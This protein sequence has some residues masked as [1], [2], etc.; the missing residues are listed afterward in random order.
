MLDRSKL[1]N[2]PSPDDSVYQHL[3]TAHQYSEKLRQGQ[4]AQMRKLEEL[5]AMKYQKKKLAFLYESSES[6]ID[7]KL[8]AEEQDQVKRCRQMMKYSF[9]RDFES[10]KQ[11]LEDRYK[12]KGWIKQHHKVIMSPDLQRSITRRDNSDITKV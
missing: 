5:R 3:T 10:R 7:I 6:E 11:A 2:S 4:L 9:E 12:K 1:K 8:D